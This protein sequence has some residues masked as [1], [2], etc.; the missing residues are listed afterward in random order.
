LNTTS[1]KETLAPAGLG[2]DCADRGRVVDAIRFDYIPDLTEFELDTLI[3]LCSSVVVELLQN[4]SGLFPSVF[5][6]QPARTLLQEPDTR[7]QN[8]GGNALESK[9]ETPCSRR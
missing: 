6:A 2:E 3:S 4:S 7:N 8:D 1:K 5:L 9:R